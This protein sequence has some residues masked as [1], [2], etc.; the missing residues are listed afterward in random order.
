VKT[1]I[2]PFSK[3]KIIKNSILNIEKIQS[4]IKTKFSSNI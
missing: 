1:E 3:N 2:I 4:E